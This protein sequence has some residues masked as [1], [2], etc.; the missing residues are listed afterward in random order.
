MPRKIR[1]FS[2]NHELVAERRKQIAKSAA[3]L[4]L[5]QGY[6]KTWV[7]EIGAACGMSMGTLYHYVGSKKDILYMIMDQGMI[8]LH[9]FIDIVTANYLSDSISPTKALESTV[10]LLYQTIEQIGDIITF[11]YLESKN[12]E[13]DLVKKAQQEKSEDHEV[14]LCPPTSL[15]LLGYS[16]ATGSSRIHSLKFISWSEY[17]IPNSLILVH[18]HF[19][20]QL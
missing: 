20:T 11:I 12:F 4:F 17:R 13:K 19:M 10:Q 15:F 16:M 5:K 8:P 9:R 18:L 3:K 14:V 1:S 7:R 6:E 2:S